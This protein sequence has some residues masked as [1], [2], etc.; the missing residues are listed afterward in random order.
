MS[1]PDT[2][3]GTNSASSSATHSINIQFDPYDASQESF[4]LYIMRLE[5]YMLC[6]NIQADLKKAT[7]ITVMGA[8]LF[9]QLVNICRPQL[10]TEFSYDEL[11]S[12]LKSHV[13]PEPNFVAERIRLRQTMQHEGESV[14][15][16]IVR[17][18]EAA[19]HCKYVNCDHQK[20][21]DEN[22]RDQFIYGI[23][24]HEIRQRLISKKAE[25]S[26]ACTMAL[27]M[28]LIS[29]ETH[30]MESGANESVHK[31]SYGNKRPN[32]EQKYKR[33][34]EIESSSFA[35]SNHSSKIRC[36]R[37]GDEH[38]AP[39]C[40]YKNVRCS[41]CKKVGHLSRV[42]H[43]KN[44]SNNVHSNGKVHQ[45]RDDEVIDE[46]DLDTSDSSNSHNNDANLY[47]CQYG[48]SVVECHAYDTEKT[49]VNCGKF[50]IDVQMDGKP[51]TMEFDT[52]GAVS[53][54]NIEHYKEINPNQ[55]IL[56]TQLM[57]KSVTQNMIKPIGYVR[58]KVRYETQWA[59]VNLYLVH[60][61][62]N[63]TFGREWLSQ[64]HVKLA[65]LKQLNVEK[66]A[67][68]NLSLN[69]LINEFPEMFGDTVKCS[70]DSTKQKLCAFL[71]QYRKV[72][73]VSAGHTSTMF[74]NDNRYKPMLSADSSKMWR[75]DT[76]G[77]SLEY[78]FPARQSFD[79]QRQF[80]GTLSG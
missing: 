25:F 51:I 22:M 80:G 70:N 56:P 59:T 9:R 17:L 28:E 45:Q 11:V 63:A 5:Q 32:A 33:S 20:S 53:I 42:C 43:S 64:F 67:N 75:N 4:D 65:S 24:S 3:T 16:F 6:H 27:D 15:N 68:D 66:S 10:P 52:G 19:R 69:Q 72:S 30:S 8:T 46:S 38:L 44:R 71:N 35:H 58:V 40:K 13:D 31:F 49:M 74:K 36:F 12:K 48:I 57:L 21:L 78:Q 1:P 14:S 2:S 55:T 47:E 60:E 77:K 18:K 7:L 50:M 73:C 29:K 39:D 76:V 62:I 54:M 34:H 23:R 41:F 79:R 37:C 61:Q 26:S